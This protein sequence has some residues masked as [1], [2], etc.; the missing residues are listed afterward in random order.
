MPGSH[1]NTRPS[2]SGLDAHDGRMVTISVRGV[3]G[4][5]PWRGRMAYGHIARKHEGRGPVTDA[6]GTF[7]HFVRYQV[8]R[9]GHLV[10]T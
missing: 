8:A 5:S 3:T 10:Q 2:G 1:V 7:P 9:T 4:L 6:A